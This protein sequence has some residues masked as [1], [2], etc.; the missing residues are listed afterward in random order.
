MWFY[1][2]LAVFVLLLAFWVSR[3][4]LF[5][6]FLRAHDPG[7]VGTRPGGAALYNDTK[8]LTRRRD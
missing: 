4:N 1:I 2:A 8:D 3:T 6:H 7:Q 5:R